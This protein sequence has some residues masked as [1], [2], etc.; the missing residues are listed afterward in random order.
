MDLTKFGIPLDTRWN[1]AAGNLHGGANA[2]ALALDVIKSEG[3][4][5]FQREKYAVIEA[6]SVCETA[7][8]FAF[9]VTGQRDPNKLLMYSQSGKPSRLA[10]CLAEK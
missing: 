3:A 7:E 10:K 4:P 2:V 9:V 8:D 5:F 6:V 1:D